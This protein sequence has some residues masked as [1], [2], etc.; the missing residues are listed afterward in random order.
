[1]D[2]CDPSGARLVCTEGTVTEAACGDGER[3]ADGVCC[4]S[5]EHAVAAASGG[6]CS[7]TCAAGYTNQGTAAAPN[8]QKP[9]DCKAFPHATATQEGGACV[10]SCDAGY[11]NSGTKAAPTCE[12]GQKCEGGKIQRRGGNTDWTKPADC[13]PEKICYQEDVATPGECVDPKGFVFKMRWTPNEADTEFPLWAQAAGSNAPSKIDVD[14]DS[15]G[16]W[17]AED[18]AGGQRFTCHSR[19]PTVIT[20]RGYMQRLGFGGRAS[21]GNFSWKT[22]PGDG[23]E[24][25]QW[26]KNP[27]QDMS[28]LLFNCK[29]VVLAEGIDPPNLV[30]TRRMW[31]TFGAIKAFSGDLSTWDVSQVLEMKGLATGAKGF[32]PDISG[33]DVRN[34]KTLENAFQR[35][36]DFNQDLSGWKVDN[37]E[38]MQ[39]MFAGAEAFNGDIRSW[40]IAKVT[41]MSWMF[42]NAKV[43]N[44]DISGWDVS[45]V[46]SVSGMFMGASSFTQD[47]SGWKLDSV[48]SCDNGFYRNSGLGPDQVP[49]VCR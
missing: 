32:N 40:N 16:T 27:W 29:T 36:T 6:S 3:C 30:Q 10:Y 26:G 25:L 8:C 15:D 2:S 31:W 37:V 43:F 21:S 22:C 41:D 45:A 20:I 47:I 1:M 17:E 19:K 9:G 13:P 48:T 33:W 49:P 23:V 42:S 18:L 46:K 11:V 38:N 39:G 44:Q 34:V 12:V 14:C 7:Y 35:T 5:F 28:E 4:P 24:V